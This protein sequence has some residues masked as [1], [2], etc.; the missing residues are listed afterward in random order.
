MVLEQHVLHRFTRP[1]H[2]RP[3]RSWPRV[4]P[5]ILMPQLCIASYPGAGPYKYQLIPL[6]PRAVV[7]F[8]LQMNNS[9]WCQKYMSDDCWLKWWFSWCA[10]GWQHNSACIINLAPASMESLGRGMLIPPCVEQA[11]A[12]CWAEF[13]KTFGENFP[14]QE[15]HIHL[16]IPLQHSVFKTVS[17]HTVTDW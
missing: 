3:N 7:N 12:R 6:L 15:G 2:I 5:C 11:Q 1:M 9:I 8:N 14:G 13:Y 4:E 16:H 17:N 10:R